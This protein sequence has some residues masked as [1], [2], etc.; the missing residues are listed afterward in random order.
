MQGSSQ[1]QR[2]AQGQ[3]CRILPL[4]GSLPP[5]QQVRSVAILGP[6]RVVPLHDPLHILLQSA[7]HGEHNISHLTAGL[8]S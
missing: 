7:L 5:D 8:L 1:L 3:S 4:H 6:A 2:A